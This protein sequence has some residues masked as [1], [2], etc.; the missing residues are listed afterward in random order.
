MSR[1]A[2]TMLLSVLL[3]GAGFAWLQ[4]DGAPGKIPSHRPL[5]DFPV[6]VGDWSGI[7]L[8]IDKKTAEILNAD[9][10]ASILFRKTGSGI[11]GPQILFFGVYYDRQTPEKNIHSP[12]NCLPSSGWAVLKRRT[13]SLSL[14]PGAPPVSASYD[15]IQKGL[16]RQLVLYWYQER[17]RTFSNDYLGRY[18]MIRD[19][20]L[21]RRTDGAMV[22][23]SM[24]IGT[25][26][27]EALA[28]EVRFLGNLAPLLSRYI[29]G[30]EGDQEVVLKASSSSSASAEIL[31]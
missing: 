14:V 13:V 25:T 26:P 4:K 12:E 31:R 9:G 8:P 16:E 19:A 6:K 29:P 27:R 10:T 30:G 5:A 3:M 2:L 28:Q 1:R 11:G 15:I 7:R 17:G 21:M 20:L 22:R 18:Y 24:P 23:V